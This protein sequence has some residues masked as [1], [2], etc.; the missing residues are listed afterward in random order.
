MYSRKLNHVRIEF[1][2]TVIL[3]IGIFLILFYYEC[4][5][6]TNYPFDVLLYDTK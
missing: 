3:F 6:K 4:I 1:F 5:L 2:R